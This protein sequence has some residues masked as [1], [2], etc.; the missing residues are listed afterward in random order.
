M[1]ELGLKVNFKKRIKEIN[2]YISQIPD[3][4]PSTKNKERIDSYIRVSII[5]LCSHFEGAL[6]DIIETFIKDINQL[7]I[8]CND[9]DT[10]LY[11]KNLFSNPNTKLKD[12]N[13][14]IN[15]LDNYKTALNKSE[16]ITLNYEYFNN[17]ES[18]PTPEII[19]KMFRIFGYDNIIDLLN[20]EIN[21]LAPS[22]E[23]SDFFKESEKEQLRS[24]LSDRTIKR[25][26]NILEKSRPNKKQVYKYG[27][28]KHINDL[29]LARHKIVHG[30][31]D[32]K[33]T[34]QAVI[35]LKHEIFKLLCA[36]YKKLNKNLVT[37]KCN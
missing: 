21:N 33:L 34:R 10:R 36:L 25:I 4:I 9:L 31:S 16:I 2:F 7:N 24:F 29:L 12:I 14:V 3:E 37:M 22:Y 6:K 18:N 23:Q 15:V 19:I 30:D 27:F 26:S 17:T 20:S 8:K 35:E 5:L 32:F 28:Y 1:G 11:A 13:N